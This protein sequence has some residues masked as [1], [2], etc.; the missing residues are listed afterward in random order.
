MRQLV[1]F[2]HTLA[3]A[4]A[5]V[6]VLREDLALL[7][8]RKINAGQLRETAHHVVSLL[9]LLWISGLALLVL[10]TGFNLYDLPNKPKIA[11]KLTVVSLLTLNGLALHAVA[12]PLL[13][14]PVRE[15]R[16]AATVCVLLGAVSTV[17]WLYASFIGV[18][19]LIAPAMSFGGFVAIYVGLLALACWVGDKWVRPQLSRMMADCH[20]PV[21]QDLVDQPTASSVVGDLFAPRPLPRFVLKFPEG[22]RPKG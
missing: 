7:R 13:T 4:F 22:S 5:I 16:W 14:R 10:D 17:S 15:V 11:A 19:R 1:L 20:E 9:G 6:A 21:T 12:F 8:A 2:A 3:F 18:A